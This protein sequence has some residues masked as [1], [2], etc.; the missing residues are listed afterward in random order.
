MNNKDVL[1]REIEELPEEKLRK[2]IDY[3]RLLKSRQQ[4]KEL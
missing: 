4:E 2:V 1:I 3:V